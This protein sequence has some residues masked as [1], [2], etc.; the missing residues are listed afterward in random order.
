M[1]DRM[2]EDELNEIGEFVERGVYSGAMGEQMFHRIERLLSEV[3]QLKKEH[4]NAFGIRHLRVVE[5]ERDKA[6]AIAVELEQQL[7]EIQH[8]LGEIALDRERRD[9]EEFSGES[10]TAFRTAEECLAVVDDVT[11]PIPS[12]SFA[13]AKRP[14]QDRCDVTAADLAVMLDEVLKHVTALPSNM[15]YRSRLPAAPQPPAKAATRARPTASD[16]PAGARSAS[17]YASDQAD[18]RRNLADFLREAEHVTFADTVQRAKDRLAAPT[19]DVSSWFELSYSN[20]AVL[21]RVELEH[22]PEGWQHRFVRMLDELE[23]AYAHLDHPEG[24]EVYP[25]RWVLVEDLTEAEAKA[26]GVTGTLDDFPGLPDDPTREE[27]DVHDAAFERASAN[28]VFYDADG[29]ELDSQSRI[30]I[31]IPDPI[32]HYR[33]GRVEPRLT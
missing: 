20:F 3:D 30:P 29:N 9:V 23:A 15:R 4:W 7:G 13:A 25:A 28:Q 21:H 12:E 10:V 6:R 1:S 27:V 14:E 33:H 17:Q 26:A 31:R 8:R 18:P 16:R 22:M 5:A 11:D 19:R 32:P 2:T 24:Y